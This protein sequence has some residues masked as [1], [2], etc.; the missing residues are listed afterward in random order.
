MSKCWVLVT[1]S[2]FALPLTSRR[3]ETF[4]STQEAC[5][6]VYVLSCFFKRKLE[7]SSEQRG[8]RA[9][10]WSWQLSQH[11]SLGQELRASDASRGGR[12]RTQAVSC[13]LKPLLSVTILSLVRSSFDLEF[14]TTP[15]LLLPHCFRMRDS[16]TSLSLRRRVEAFFLRSVGLCTDCTVSLTRCCSG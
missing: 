1:L 15:I 3:R 11:S 13:R 10:R 5:I 16:E 9:W 2:E 4:L 14:S 8:W 12:A 7:R 6:G